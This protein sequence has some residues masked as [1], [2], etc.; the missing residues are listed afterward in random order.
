MSNCEQLKS[1]AFAWMN[2]QIKAVKMMRKSFH[3]KVSNITPPVYNRIQVHGL[4][5]LSEIT[6]IPYVREPW[7]GNKSQNVL[8]DII[9]FT[10]DGYRFFEL[11]DRED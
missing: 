8:Y 7:E 6:D 10:Y 3:E 11:L 2:K 1:N 4:I 5:E 9:Y